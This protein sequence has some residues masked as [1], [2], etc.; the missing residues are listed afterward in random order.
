LEL[1][2]FILDLTLTDFEAF[3]T[4]FKKSLAEIGVSEKL[5]EE[6]KVNK[7]DDLRE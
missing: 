3:I 2:T 1:P 4:Q 5:I 6:I 7:I